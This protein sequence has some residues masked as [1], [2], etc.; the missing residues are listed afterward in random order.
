MRP[1][2]GITLRN[3]AISFLGLDKALRYQRLEG[4]AFWRRGEV[5]VDLPNPPEAHLVRYE[6]DIAQLRQSDLNDFDLVVGADG[7]HRWSESLID[8]AEQGDERKIREIIATRW[9]ENA[10]PPG[11]LD[12]CSDSPSRASPQ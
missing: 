10:V 1:G 8:A 9:A 12:N 3:D 11:P 6:N 7:A 2:F 4:R 5:I